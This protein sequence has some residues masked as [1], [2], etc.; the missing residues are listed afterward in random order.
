MPCVRSPSYLSYA[1][2]YCMSIIEE[3]TGTTAI[4]GTVFSEIIIWDVEK[5]D[6]GLRTISGHEVHRNF[7]LQ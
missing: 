3:S 1:G 6:N 7:D 4:S 2:S 5:P